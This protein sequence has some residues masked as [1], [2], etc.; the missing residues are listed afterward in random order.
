MV[1]NLSEDYMQVIS[2]TKVKSSL[3]VLPDHINEETFRYLFE[4]LSMTL[5]HVTTDIIANP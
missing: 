2:H 1:K 3:I 4:I 5:K